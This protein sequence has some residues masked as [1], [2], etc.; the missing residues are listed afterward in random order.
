MSYTNKT[1]YGI[2][3]YVKFEF[4]ESITFYKLMNPEDF[5]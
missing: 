2:H 5:P 4:P 3:Q 1:G